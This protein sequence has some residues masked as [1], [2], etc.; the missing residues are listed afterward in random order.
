MPRPRTTNICNKRLRHAIER[1]MSEEGLT[2]TEI[3]KRRGCDLR[4][5]TEFFQDIG[6]RKHR[7]KTL[8]EF[9]RALGKPATWLLDLLHE[10]GFHQ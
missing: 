10:N 5:V 6:T 4:T 9:S 7:L 2:Y 1:H 8:G 3:A